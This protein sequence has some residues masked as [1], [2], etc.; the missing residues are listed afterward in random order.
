MI[1]LRYHIVSIVAVFLALGIGTALGG[2]LLDR[3]TVDLL[4]QSISSAETRITRT[5]QENDRLSGQVRASE[6]RDRALLETAGPSL[7]RDHLT[8]VPVLVVTAPGI[9][10]DAT[11]DLRT[12][13]VDSGADLRGTLELRDAL[14]FSGDVDADLA[15]AVGA[16]ATDR[17]AV[18]TGVIR[19]MRN[20]LLAASAAPPTPS[21]PP[22]GSTTIPGDP[23]T[24]PPSSQPSSTTAPPSTAPPTSSTT[25]PASSVEP[26]SGSTEVDGTQP[27]IVT[28][29]ISADYARFRPGPGHGDQDPILA[30]TGYR[31]VFV[32]APGLDRSANDVLLEFLTSRETEKPIKAVVVSASV[33]TP[34]P[35]QDQEQVPTAVAQVRTS[36][37]LADRYS[38]VDDLDVFAGQVSTVLALENLARPITGHYGDAPGATAVVAPST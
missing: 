27:E 32:S 38:T 35:S 24:V 3:Y 31:Y 36:K 10:A 28:A 4:Q 30:T 22:D 7:L 6:A 18:R 21:L 15:T 26:G 37:E 13:L 25:L 20:A 23:S 29:L 2:T 9:D 8:N 11:A 16:D 34:P 14:T 1:N 5:E 12:A 17:G 19:R 33:P